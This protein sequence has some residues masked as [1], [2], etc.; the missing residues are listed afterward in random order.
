MKRIQTHETADRATPAQ[1]QLVAD[2]RDDNCVDRLGAP[3]LVLFHGGPFDGHERNQHVP[4]FDLRI[5]MPMSPDS[6]GHGSG[7]TC[8]AI[9]EARRAT[10]ELVDGLPTMKV[11]FYFAGAAPRT[12]NF[13]TRIIPQ[14]ARWLRR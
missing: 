8:V 5:E 2:H 7:P 3:Y 9:Y 6:S 11:R 1:P 13:L 14:L 4:P 12:R 10:L